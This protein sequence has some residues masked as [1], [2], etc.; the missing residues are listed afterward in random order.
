MDYSDQIAVDSPPD[1]PMNETGFYKWLEEH[2]DQSFKEYLNDI[3]RYLGTFGWVAGDVIDQPRLD[4][5]KHIHQ[6]FQNQPRK[7]L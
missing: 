7:P 5:L 1:V 2:G 3:K 4:N 6:H